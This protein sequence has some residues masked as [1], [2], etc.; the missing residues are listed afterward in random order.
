VLRLRRGLKG[1]SPVLSVLLMIV[2]AVTASIIAYAAFMGYL[3]FQTRQIGKEIQVQ[4]VAQDS[5]GRLIV[6]VQNVGQGTVQFDPSGCLYVDRNLESVTVDPAGGS[7]PEGQ[8]ATLI[9]VNPVVTSNILNIKV[10][11]TDGAYTEAQTPIR[12]PPPASLVTVSSDP[13]GSGLVKVDGVNINTP[14]TF[15]WEV[16]TVHSLEALS[17]STTGAG[18]KWI[19]WSDGGE[20]VHNYTAPSAPANVT[21]I[22]KASYYLTV[23][24]GGHGTAS[25][26]G[27]YDA[28]S[29]ASFSITPKTVPGQTG[30]QYV[31]TAWAGSGAGSYSG[32]Q[33][34]SSVVMNGPITETANWKTQYYLN[35]NSPR[36]TTIGAGWYDAGS[37]VAF[38]VN[39]AIVSG[40]TGIQAVF[41][42]WSGVGSGSYS[43]PSR[44]YSTTLNNPVNETAVWKTQ[45]YLTVNSPYGTVGGSGWYDDGATAQATVS[46]LVVAGPSGTQYVFLRWSGDASGSSSPSNNIL[47]NGPKTA[48]ATWKTQFQVSFAVNPAWGNTNPPPGTINWYDSGTSGVPISA[49]ANSGYAFSTWSSPASISIANPYASSTTATINGQGTITANFAVATTRIRITSSPSTGSGF[50][51]VDGS[52]QTTPF[53]AVWAVG[54]SHQ[55]SAISPVSRSPG[56]QLVWTSW[57][58]GGAQTHT[59]TVPSSDDSITANYKTQCYLTVSSSH[60]SPFPQSNWFDSGST[61]TASVASP[62][63]QIGN[64]RFICTGWM[65]TGSVPASGTGTSTTFTINSA[66]SITWNWVP[67]CQVTFGVTPSGGGTTYPSGAS[68]Y[69][70]G[71][72]T[73]ISAIPNAH[74]LFISWSSS[75]SIQITSITSSSTT[76]TFNGPGSVT[77]SFKIPTAIDWSSPPSDINLGDTENIMG[78]LHETG[79]LLTGVNGRTVTFIFTA[80]NGTLFSAPVTTAWYGFDGACQVSFKPGSPGTWSVYAQFDGDATYMASK[81]STGTFYV[82]PPVKITITSSPITGSGIILVDGVGRSTPYTATW[83]VGSTHMIEAISPVSGGS[84]LQLKW[85]SWSDGGAQ[86]HIYTVPASASTVT[87]SYR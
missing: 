46:P 68:W 58:D 74:F 72:S 19:S 35:V 3:N 60:D 30:T 39:P 45:Y 22:F 9:S 38:N 70:V 15:V 65:G 59:Y 23:I 40:G 36:G 16:G 1:I 11:V 34:S 63:D 53:T 31:F 79:S 4:S 17:S 5:T 55:I 80:P 75:G 67:Q 81:S 86:Q 62:A 47:M 49:M 61:V 76:A 13:T 54:S 56:V 7:L 84:G 42:G 85:V 52:P 78:I 69:N 12:N 10:V 26:E 18:T 33:M 73:Q 29:T 82:T 50:L 43:G 48:T 20:Q 66:S 28:G 8:I 44:S 21:A 77:A 6:Y 2:V 32:P 27:W 87:A 83:T 64:S 14:R 51:I 37:T 71:S 25:G 41:M 57:S 24:D